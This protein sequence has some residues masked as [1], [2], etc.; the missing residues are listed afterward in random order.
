[1][2][3]VTQI[4]I[5]FLMRTTAASGVRTYSELMQYYLGPAWQVLTLLHLLTS[6]CLVGGV[7]QLRGGLSDIRGSG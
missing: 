1:M 6:A 2:H 3:V 7:G 4:T 5:S